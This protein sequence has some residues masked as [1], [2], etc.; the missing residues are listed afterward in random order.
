V[1]LIWILRLVELLTFCSDL[2]FT[3]KAER[4]FTNDHSSYFKHLKDV[5][6]RVLEGT[7]HA[8]GV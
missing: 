3:V 1:G 8:F 6:Y 4:S 5:V 2:T 7:S